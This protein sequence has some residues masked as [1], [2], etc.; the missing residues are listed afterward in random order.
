MYG[1]SPI[2]TSSGKTVRHRANRS[3][4]RQANHALWRIVMVR[5]SHKDPATMA[6]VERRSAQGKSDRQIVR[7]LK[8]HVAREVYRHLVRP[9]VVPVGA[10]LRADRL[11][12][13]IS[14]QTVADAIGSWPTRISELEG[15][16]RHDT[17]L[18]RRYV[19]WL[20]D[21]SRNEEEAPPRAA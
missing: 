9:E 19:R 11:A 18:A 14:L 12:A 7:C 4:N 21:Q 15:G 16:L 5:L 17:D 8:R 10:D 3:G 6:Y 1:V 2:E 13:R 20:A